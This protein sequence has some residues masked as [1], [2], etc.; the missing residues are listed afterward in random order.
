MNTVM[1]EV[2]KEINENLKKMVET[3]AIN[4]IEGTLKINTL[5]I[6]FKIWEPNIIREYFISIKI[7]D[8]LKTTYKFNGSAEFLNKE[9]NRVFEIKEE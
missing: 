1:K 3:P 7:L 8:K 4:S 9:L 2:I 5:K 6:E